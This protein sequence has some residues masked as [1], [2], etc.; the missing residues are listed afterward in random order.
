MCLARSKK[1]AGSTSSDIVSWDS[2]FPAFPVNK[3]KI[4]IRNQSNLDKSIGEMSLADDLRGGKR[5]HTASSKSSQSSSRIGERKTYEKE[6]L[7]HSEPSSQMALDPGLKFFEDQPGPYPSEHQPSGRPNPSQG[8]NGTGSMH[9]VKP[10]INQDRRS[11]DTMARPS[12]HFNGSESGR[13]KTMPLSISEAVQ[14][15]GHQRGYID[16]PVWQEPDHNVDHRRRESVEHF[17]SRPIDPSQL[18]RTSRPASQPGMTGMAD[19]NE[20]LNTRGVVSRPPHSAQN[21][22]GDFYDS[23]Y[24]TSQHD[25]QS[26]GQGQNIQQLRSP[27]EDMPNFDALPRTNTGYSQGMTIDD[28]LPPQQSLPEPRQSSPQHR[29]GKIR[30]SRSTG[31][32]AGQLFRSKSQ[33]NL[34]DQYSRSHHPNNDFVFDLPGDVPAVPPIA[35]LKDK[36]GPQDFQYPNNRDQS[37]DQEARIR[38]E[39]GGKS[40]FNGPNEGVRPYGPDQQSF[41]PSERYRSPPPQ[42]EYARDGPSMRPGSRPGSRPNQTNASGPTSPAIDSPANPGVLPPHPVPIRPGLMQGLSH[43]QSAKP[44]P[45]RQYNSGPLEPNSSQQPGAPPLLIAK[46][47]SVPVTLE[48]LER[49]KQAVKSKPSDQKAQLD[50]AKKLVEAS[51]VLVD[52]DGRT[53]QKA[54]TKAREKYILDAHKIVK[55][56]VHSNS[57]DATFY[58]ADCYSRG[59]LGLEVDTKEAFALY[60]TAAKAG[61]AQS[62]YRVAVC[63]EM[64]Q[65]EGGGTRRDPQKAMQWYKRAATLGDTPAMYKIGIIKLKGL[66][67]QPKESQEA[68]IWLRRAADRADE[69]NPHALHELV[70]WL[71]GHEMYQVLTVHST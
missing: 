65:D 68:L 54:K 22:L 47:D 43:E 71:A 32:I 16:Q 15:D 4:S 48:E 63:C 34:D 62:A 64:G 12:F 9:E 35:P 69:E 8:L 53:D 29:S 7:D 61:H 41:Q 55:K 5:P 44:H 37:I 50:L 25:Q 19:G 31:H 38:N 27:E 70:S 58:L 2:P 1:P 13:S 56:L 23:Y 66:L 24:N 45:I 20:G 30:P 49:L 60:Q 46:R 28:H 6:R 67:G 36:F 10:F 42:S 51:S 59:L 33:P 26:Y 3:G 18:S 11:E 52:N 21:S 39:Y 14:K 40:P 57:V 17:Q